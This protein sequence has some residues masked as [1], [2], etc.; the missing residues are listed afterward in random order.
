MKRLTLNETWKLCLSMWWW[1]AGQ[2]K[3]GN[4]SNI[5]NLKWEWLEGHGFDYGEISEDCF[6]CEYITQ[7][8]IG[9]VNCPGKMVS[10][11][12]SCT[13]TTYHYQSKPIAFYNK[14]VSLNRKRR[15]KQGNR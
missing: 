7:K 9:C 2:K 6:F 1:I 10:K 8:D 4:T 11:R 14:L 12:F 5:N 15:K 3:K 13:K